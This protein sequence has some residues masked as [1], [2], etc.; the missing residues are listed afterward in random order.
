MQ[1]RPTFVALLLVLFIPVFNAAAQTPPPAPTLIS[2]TSG[3]TV[4][5]P[6]TLQWTAVS[7]PDGPIGSYIWQVGTTSS[8]GVVIASGF[9]DTRNGDPIPTRDRVSGLPNATYFWRVKA[10]QTVGRAKLHRQRSRPRAVR[11]AHD[12]G[13]RQRLALP[14]VRV[15]QDHMD[16]GAGRPVLHPRSRRRAELLVSVDAEPGPDGIWH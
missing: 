1:P 8:F 16:G 13:P 11:L 5:Q 3:A 6:L 14:P 10:T 12:H 4:A 7:D 9:T 15:L 2:P